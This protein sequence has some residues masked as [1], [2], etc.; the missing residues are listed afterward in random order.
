M[1]K[2]QYVLTLASNISFTVFLFVEYDK[3]VVLVH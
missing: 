2:V 3:S 1:L